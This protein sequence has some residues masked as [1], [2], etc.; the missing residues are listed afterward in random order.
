MRGWPARPGCTS[1]DAK[2]AKSRP[3]RSKSTVSGFAIYPIS[4]RANASTHVLDACPREN[5]RRNSANF[6][7]EAR[8]VIG[9]SGSYSART[10]PAGHLGFISALS[11]AAWSA[12][13]RCR[14]DHRGSIGYEHRR[15][16]FLLTVMRTVEA[17]LGDL[18]G[19]MSLADSDEPVDDCGAA[20]TMRSPLASS[21]A[22]P[23]RW[24]TICRA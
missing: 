22:A 9:S 1:R 19:Q 4:G 12:A 8:T 17:L 13:R 5:R 2:V 23:W 11:C 16:M 20:E 18:A 10:Y 3:R 21:S 7:A 14:S 15:G 24:A 6:L